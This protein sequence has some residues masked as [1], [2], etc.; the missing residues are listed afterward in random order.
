MM[1]TQT[2][3]ELETWDTTLATIIAHFSA[4]LG[5]IHFL[6]PEDNCLH[7][8][9]ASEGIPE[10]VLAV[11][12]C[13]PMGKGIAGT[14]AFTKEPTTMCN[15][16]TDQSGVAKPGAK[17]TQ[18]QGSICVPVMHKGDVVGTLGIGYFREREFTSEETKDLLKIGENLAP[19]LIKM[20][21]YHSTN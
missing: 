16:Q 12:R 21:T 6:N 1:N 9:R 2:K 15:L 13:I 18:S 8:V 3:I 4:D 17:A 20:N 5:M 19:D 10:Q 7:L 11:T 14:A